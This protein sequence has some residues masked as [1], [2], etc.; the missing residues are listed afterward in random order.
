[1]TTKP[2]ETDNPK[3]L[4]L[5]LDLKSYYPSPPFQLGLLA[6]YANTD[7]SVRESIEFRFAEY[8]RDVGLEQICQEVLDSGAHLI[9][10][11]N[12]AWNAGRLEGLLDLLSGQKSERPWVVLGGPNCTGDY[13]RK[14]LQDFPV[15]SAVVQGEGE[16]AILDICRSLVREP[17]Q[18]PFQESRNCVLDSGGR[19]GGPGLGHRIRDLDD[20][21][22]PYRTRILPTSPSPVFY[23]TNRGCPYRCGFCYWG[24]GN[25]RVY[26]HSLERIKQDV[27]FFASNKVRALWLADANFGLFPD[28]AEIA[29]QIV[30]VNSHH[31]SPLRSVGVNWAKNSSERILDI[32]SIFQENGIDCSTTIALQS[33][34][35]EAEDLSKRYSIPVK[36]FV[37]LVEAA[38]ARDVDTY[39]DLILG[40]PGED[41]EQFTKGLETVSYTGVPVIKIHQLVLIPGTEFYERRLEFGFLTPNVCES[42]MV[43]S[44]ERADFYDTTVI[45]HPKLSPEEMV[46]AKKWMGVSHLFHNHGLGKA[47]NLFLSGLGVPLKDIYSAFI[48]LLDGGFPEFQ[49]SQDMLC[50]LRSVFEYFLRFMGADE[51]QYYAKLSQWVWWGETKNGGEVR[52]EKLAKLFSKF[53]D[54]LVEKMQL[55]LGPLERAV[56]QELTHFSIVLAPKP[57]WRPLEEYQYS[58]DV[59]GLYNDLKS[60]QQSASQRLQKESQWSDLTPAVLKSLKSTLSLTSDL[61]SRMRICRYKVSNPWPFPPS[62]MNLD[63]LVTLKSKTPRVEE[64]T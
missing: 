19:T 37:T 38:G 58:A 12:Y 63:W 45:G 16:P 28:D 2:I 54:I 29:R 47:S 25:S 6:S 57:G 20:I 14:L 15:V 9:A 5:L 39:T 17:E 33:I 24:N 21:P 27:A 42:E 64:L 41:L 8:S 62:K 40:L 13:G 48:E 30:E 4:V 22:S 31:G 50:E 44:S 56:L 11:S 36:K 34:T 51:N 60:S 3:R 55:R 23:E 43:P 35:P 52:V 26:R 61:S 59:L 46:V 10:A 53:Y 18:N 49:G 32:A 1:V 7:D